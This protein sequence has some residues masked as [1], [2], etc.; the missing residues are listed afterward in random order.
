MLSHV[1]INR[2]L[3]DHSTYCKWPV[4]TC[5]IQMK[6]TVKKQNKTKENQGYLKCMATGKWIKEQTQN[7]HLLKEI[8][9]E[10]KLLIS[11]MLHKCQ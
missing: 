4:P 8:T 5:S 7:M 3:S 9:Q 1:S 11:V 10:H 2:S 6:S